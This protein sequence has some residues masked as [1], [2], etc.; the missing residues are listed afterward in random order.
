MMR[1][2]E[3]TVKRKVTLLCAVIMAVVLM[4]NGCGGQKEPTMAMDVSDEKTALITANNSDDGDFLLAGSIVVEEG[5]EVCIDSA[6]DEG[7]INIEFL[8]IGGESIN[9]D[10]DDI[11]SGDVAWNDVVSGNDTMNCSFGEGEFS[12]KATSKGKANGTVM[13]NVVDAKDESTG[14]EASTVEETA[15][16]A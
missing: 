12:I 2:G 9:A 13:I 6:L 10:I 14:P 15:A 16:D 4:L 11:T 1:E 8:V 5:E 3:N 7:E